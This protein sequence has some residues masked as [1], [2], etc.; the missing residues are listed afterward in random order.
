L[1]VGAAVHGA[2]LPPVLHGFKGV[3]NRW[4]LRSDHGKKKMKK[5]KGKKRRMK[6]GK[7]MQWSTDQSIYQKPNANGQMIQPMNTNRRL[8]VLTNVANSLFETV[9]QTNQMIDRSISNQTAVTESGFFSQA[10]TIT[11]DA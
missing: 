6:G 8:M 10:I 5:G 7:E 3:F 2:R 4:F 9:K 11:N 1:L